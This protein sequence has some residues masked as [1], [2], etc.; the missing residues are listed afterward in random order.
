MNTTGS[1]FLTYST[2]LPP[3]AAAQNSIDSSLAY[4]FFYIGRKTS[5]NTYYMKT[6]KDGLCVVND[7]TSLSYTPTQ[8]FCWQFVPRGTNYVIM[9]T[10][11]TNQRLVLGT[12]KQNTPTLKLSLLTTDDL[13]GPQKDQIVYL[14]DL[15]R[16]G[17][18]II[19]VFKAAL[20]ALA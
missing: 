12:L 11:A 6:F 19:L 15:T 17:M 2:N 16:E 20:A 4:Q 3:I 7:G 13:N 9:S 10:T 5:N 8:S 18:S 1:S 14:W